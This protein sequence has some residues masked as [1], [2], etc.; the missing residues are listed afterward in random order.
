MLT[1]ALPHS[2]RSKKAAKQDCAAAALQAVIQFREPNE[3]KQ[4]YVEWQRK[5][6]ST[7]VPEGNFDFTQDQF[8]MNTFMPFGGRNPGE[9]MTF[10]MAQPIPS[11]KDSNGQ[12]LKRKKEQEPEEMAVDP[13]D[14]AVEQP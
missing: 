6:H 9:A 11:L 3:A 5:N 8:A 2:F 12:G 13:P 7:F 14:A 1:S 4:V 10:E